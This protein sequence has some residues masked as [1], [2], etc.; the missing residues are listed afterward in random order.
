MEDLATV[1]IQGKIEKF[2]TL[3]VDPNCFNYKVDPIVTAPTN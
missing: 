1:N 2:S 3:T